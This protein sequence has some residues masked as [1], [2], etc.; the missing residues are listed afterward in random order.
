MLFRSQQNTFTQP[1]LK[2]ETFISLMNGTVTDYHLISSKRIA[3][4]GL[5]AN[6]GG[7]HEG[8]KHKIKKRGCLILS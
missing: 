5:L 6:N 8:I 7:G 1:R 3:T 2:D 4:Y